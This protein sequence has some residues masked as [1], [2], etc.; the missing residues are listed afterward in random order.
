MKI[1]RIDV[2]TLT[3]LMPQFPDYGL[4][5]RDRLPYPRQARKRGRS[6]MQI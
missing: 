4:E 3:F 6:V 5:L 1:F 2:I